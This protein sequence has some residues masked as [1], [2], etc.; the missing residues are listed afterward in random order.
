[1]I[2]PIIAAYLY[3]P[4]PVTQNYTTKW[5]IQDQRTFDGAMVRCGQL[6]PEAPCLKIFRK[7]DSTTYNV[8]CGKQNE[9]K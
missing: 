3:C 9:A 8:I 1:M 2:G 5:N 4:A 7:K 6:Y